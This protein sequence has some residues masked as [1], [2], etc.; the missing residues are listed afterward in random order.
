MIKVIETN[1]SMDTADN[2]MDH[3]SRIIEVEDW[4]SFVNEI[5]E[6]KTILRNSCIGN[7]H[8][9]TIPK[10]AKVENII[11]DDFHLSCDIYNYVGMKSKKLIYKV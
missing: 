6:A 1:L 10:Q 4:D 7:L 2:I 9:C 8:G 5:K 3:Q 11:Y